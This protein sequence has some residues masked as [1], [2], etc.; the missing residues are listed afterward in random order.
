MMLLEARTTGNRVTRP[1]PLA[2]LAFIA[3]A[4]LIALAILA[5]QVGGESALASFDRAFSKSLD[6]DR[7]PAWQEVFKTITLL[8]T[9]WALGIAS[10]VVAAGLR[11]LREA[12]PEATID[13]LFKAPDVKLVAL[14]SPE[15]GIRGVLDSDVP[16]EKDER[17]GL[18]IHPGYLSARVTLGRA[19]I[20]LNQL[21]DAQGELELV[22]KSAPENLAAIRGLGEIHHRNGDLAA[23]LVQYRAALALARNDPDLQETVAQL[24][25]QVEPQKPAAPSD[26]L[27]FDQ[28][29][30]ELLKLAPPPR[31]PETAVLS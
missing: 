22:L 29:E 8:G 6:E 21:T 23:A 7:T 10:G 4:A 20:E 30:S 18:T 3:I 2:V 11:A 24:A 26:D 12:R 31:V 28:I 9:G 14:F 1:R 15:H 25:R 16:A 17:T 19:L 27:S 5:T 13:L